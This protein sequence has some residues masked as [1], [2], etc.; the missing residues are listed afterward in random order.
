MQP[1]LGRKNVTE[2]LLL[3]GQRIT[4][5]PLLVE[6]LIKTS[7]CPIEKADLAKAWTASKELNARVNERVAERERLAEI[8]SK[9]DPK[10]IIQDGSR[11]I[12]AHDLL[13]L[14]NRRLIF[15]GHAVVNRIIS[16]NITSLGNC[17]V[18]ILTDVMVCTQE[19]GGKVSFVSPVRNLIKW[20]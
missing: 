20:L 8:C 3:V 19:V 17:S 5:Y 14:P 4:K 10:S 7:I 16:G 1:L 6:P 9:I 15:N 13:S 2:C 18:L 12:R 11:R